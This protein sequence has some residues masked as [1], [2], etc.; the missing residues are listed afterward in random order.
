MRTALGALIGLGTSNRTPRGYYLEIPGLS[1]E[2]AAACRAAAARLAPPADTATRTELL[3]RFA[4]AL[5]A[6][7]IIVALVVFVFCAVFWKLGFIGGGDVKY[8]TAT[9]LWMGPA[10]AL[11][12][13]ILLTAIALAFALVLKFLANWGFLIHGMRLPEFAKRL[14]SKIAV[15]QF[16]YG[17]PI[18][19]AAL[20]L[21]PRLFRL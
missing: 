18:G 14:F 9:S 11:P 4:G 13:I 21:L 17:F 2:V 19:V 1:A 15:N 10:L 7:N 12:F 8:L 5:D 6:Y 3:R 20:L 16:P